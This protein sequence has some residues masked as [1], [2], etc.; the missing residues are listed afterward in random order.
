MYIRFARHES[1]NGWDTITIRRQEPECKR[2][3]TSG[4]WLE[5][6]SVMVEK[7]GARYLLDNKELTLRVGSTAYQKIK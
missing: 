7:S 5:K 2:S 6:E 1:G 4:R 3:L